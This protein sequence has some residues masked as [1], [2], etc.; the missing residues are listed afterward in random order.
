MREKLDQKAA[1]QSR[2]KADGKSAPQSRG[3]PS[4]GKADGSKPN[5]KAVRLGFAVLIGVVAIVVGGIALLDDGSDSD[6]R[7]AESA[8]SEETVAL[9]ESELLE[10]ADS[11]S[12]PAFWIGP[13]VGTTSY[14]LRTAEEGTYIRYLTGGAEAGDS[15]QDFLTVATYPTPEAAQR[16]QNAVTESEGGQKLTEHD[17][18]VVLGSD[19]G[20]YVVFDDYPEVQIEIFSPQSG[21]A[22]QLAT[23]GSLKPLG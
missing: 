7:P 12:G 16:L 18:Y 20:A 9:S 22:A 6:G 15:R 1:P 3:K 13:R 21:E 19:T 14:E 2:K 8:A 11:L 4:P 23:S 5:A 17:G 10:R